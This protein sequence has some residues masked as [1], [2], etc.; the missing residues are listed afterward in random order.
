MPSASRRVAFSCPCVALS[1]D[2]GRAAA[3]GGTGPAGP[4]S[5]EDPADPGAPG[6]LIP[7]AADAMPIG[8]CA[9]RVT[10]GGDDGAR[11]AT[12]PSA[13]RMSSGRTAGVM[14]RT[15]IRSI[16]HPASW[17][18]PARRSS[19][20]VSTADRASSRRIPLLVRRSTGA[21]SAARNACTAR[22]ASPGSM[23]GSTTRHSDAS[24][25]SPSGAS[26][27]S[28]T[29]VT[30]IPSGRAASSLSRTSAGAHAPVSEISRYSASLAVPVVAPP[31]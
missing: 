31:E 21:L 12:W 14:C 11:A 25:A 20:S 1:P 4:A 16:A 9:S 15:T 7:A 10:S 28:N 19:S 6:T 23:P 18:S 22:A 24:S 29:S 2:G 30:S 13:A 27:R 3:T 26:A 17:S 8:P 5:P